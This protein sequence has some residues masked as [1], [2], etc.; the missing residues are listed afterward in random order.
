MLV[1]LLLAISAIAAPIAYGPP[2][3]YTKVGGGKVQFAG[4]NIAGFDFCTNQQGACPSGSPSV[5]V[6]GGTGAAQMTQFVQA[7]M[8]TFRLPVGWTYLTNNGDP[9]VLDP[10]NWAA[11][12]QLVQQCLS[13]GAGMCIVDVHN[14]ARYNGGIV[15]QGGPTDAQFAHFWA[16]L[17]GKYANNPKVA[18]DLM[19]EPHDLNIGTWANTV[20]ATVNEI[21]GAGANANTIFIPG[22]S[23]SSLGAFPNESGPSL[24]K[25]TDPA[26]G[27][28][29]L[30]FT[31]HQYLDADM[32]GTATSCPAAQA[33][34]GAGNVNY[35]ATWLRNNGRKA[36]LL[37]TGGG[38]TPDCISSV[39]QELTA[40]NANSDVFM[41]VTM[42]AA[43]AFEQNY[44]LYQTAQTGIFTSPGASLF[45]KA[46]APIIG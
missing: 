43:G 32:S 15:G 17:A 25:V 36:M 1:T 14:Y 11:Y 7:G 24:L 23:Y 35:V 45:M 9:S 31:M 13:S 37:E 33:V 38:N 22:T 42:W 12:D 29:K 26:G 39:T 44:P 19:N 30:V 21:R 2:T 34:T 5:D 41:G 28:D 46:V 4:V 16:T 10:N 3:T 6:A 27:T 20:Q 40:V 8:N 18:F